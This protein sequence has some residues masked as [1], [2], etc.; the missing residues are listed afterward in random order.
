MRPDFMKWPA[1]LSVISV[2]GMPS[3]WSSQTVRRAPCRKGRVSS[4]K[5]SIC[6]A[7]VDRGA[8]DAERRAVAGCGEGARVAVRE[9]GLAVGN[10][11]RAVMS[12]GAIDR[13]VLFSNQS[14][15]F[16]HAA[17]DLVEGPA[18]QGC[19]EALHAVDGPEEID[20]G[21]PG[22]REGVAD[23][24]DFGIEVWRGGVEDPEGDSH[25]GGDADGRRAADDHVL[26]GGG[27]FE[28]SRGR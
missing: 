18:A 25:R 17:A 12:D 14:G 27:D 20:G 16:H 9:N 6:F 1:M 4:A 2:V 23:E 3:C 26:D 13:D 28:V 15:L 19:V 21:G 22:T 11:G 24:F 10:E 5:T 7:R 8:D